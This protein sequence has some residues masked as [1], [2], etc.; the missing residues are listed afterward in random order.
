MQT[1]FSL[2]ADAGNGVTPSLEGLMTPVHNAIYAILTTY[3]SEAANDDSKDVCRLYVLATSLS[4]AH[5]RFCRVSNIPT[6][7]SRLQY[8]LRIA[9]AH[10]LLLTKAQEKDLHTVYLQDLKRWLKEGQPCM[11][12][13]IRHLVHILSRE[14]TIEDTTPNVVFN[15]SRTVL[16]IDGCNI[17]VS[18][19][20]SHLRH[21]MLVFREGL[22]NVI[23]NPEVLNP[24]VNTLEKKFCSVNPEDWFVEKPENDEKGYWFMEDSRNTSDIKDQMNCL[25]DNA[26]RKLFSEQDGTLVPNFGTS[27]PLPSVTTLLTSRRRRP[28]QKVPQQC[29]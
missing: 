28:L 18:K 2:A 7:L 1:L 17:A 14:A 6:R 16:T 10:H 19:I 8:V 13:S 26:A 12:N 4:N 15:N 29:R 23:N 20:K 24:L 27:K 3:P 22:E 11:F 5:G 25:M 9:A 21:A